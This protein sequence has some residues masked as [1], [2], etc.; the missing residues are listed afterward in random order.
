MHDIRAMARLLES[1]GD[2]VR[3]KRPVD[4]RFEMAAV[5]GRLEAAG[6]A[7]LFENVRGAKFPV[8]GGLFNRVDRF[9]TALGAPGASGPF[10]HEDMER[11]IDAAKAAPIQP[12]ARSEGAMRGPML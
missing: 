4:G 6:K 12:R 5:M 10:D 2:L 8:L 7:F 11:R 9:G 1:T 3:I